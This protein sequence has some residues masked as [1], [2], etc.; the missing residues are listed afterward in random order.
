MKVAIK[1]LKLVPD[2]IKDIEEEYNILKNTPEHIN[3]PQF[4]GAYYKSDEVWFVMEVKFTFPIFFFIFIHNRVK[5][6]SFRL[7][8]SCCW[9]T[10]EWNVRQKR[11]SIKNILHISRY[12][13][14]IIRHI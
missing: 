13:Y 8:R 2:Y 5:F 14:K 9:I 10:V 6:R 7:M 4:Y 1:I 12:P 11:Q 3:L